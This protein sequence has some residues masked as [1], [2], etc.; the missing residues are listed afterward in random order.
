[1]PHP[2]RSPGALLSLFLFLALVALCLRSFLPE[3]ILWESRAG[4]LLLIA[5]NRSAA[6]LRQARET[7]TLDRF[8]ADRLN[9]K[10]YPTPPA[11]IRLLGFYYAHGTNPW[12][13]TFYVFGVPYWFLLPLAAWPIVLHVRRHRRATRPSPTV[14]CPACGYDCRATPTRCPE[15]GTV[16]A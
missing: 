16:P 9:P 6:S 13:G 1:M 12:D 3:S 2:L 14:L 8:L 5:D 15:C 10:F 4:R 7:Q 11:E